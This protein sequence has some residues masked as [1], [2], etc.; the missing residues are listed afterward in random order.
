MKGKKDA[1]PN[2]ESKINYRTPIYLQLREIVRNKI[3]EGEFPP[4][5]AIPSENELAETYGINRITVRNA[6][7]ALVNEG[8][9]RRVQGKGVFVVGNK[10]EEVLEEHGGFIASVG[11]GKQFT[12]VK[13][14]SKILRPAGDKY[15]NLFN[16]DSADQIFYLRQVSSIESEPVSVEEIYVPQDIIPQLDV[17]NSSVFS[18]HDVFAFYGV[19]VYS[20]R[21]SLEITTGIAK[22]RKVLNVPDGVA[23]I[24]MECT[25]QDRSGRTIEYSKSFHRSDKCSFKIHL[26]KP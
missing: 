12:S 15:A 11:K 1:S 21:Q 20:M 14:Q 18:M 6:V 26:H 23:L 5:T 3:D 9:L 2:Q 8:I 22:A 19:K 10:M 25:Y 24:M 17:V 13:E 4:G 16:I 7:D